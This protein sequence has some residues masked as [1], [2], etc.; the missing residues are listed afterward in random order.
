MGRHK[1]EEQPKRRGRRASKEVV[2]R[3]NKPFITAK[4]DKQEAKDT[5]FYKKYPHVVPGSVRNSTPEDAKVLKHVHKRVCLVLCKC[6]KTRLVNTQDAFQVFKC[7]ACQNGK[8]PTVLEAK[9]ETLKAD[10]ASLKT[11]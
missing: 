8:D 6:G 3:L 2:E 11:A 9:I 10:L 1:R 7:L 5:A 4:A